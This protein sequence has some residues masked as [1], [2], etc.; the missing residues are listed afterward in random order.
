[1]AAQKIVKDMS[2]ADNNWYIQYSQWK[3]ERDAY[4][5]RVNAR[6]EGLAEGKAQGLAEGKAQGLAEGRSEGRSQG[7]SEK[8]L[9]D[10]KNFL[11]E[12]DSPEKIA[13]CIG[14]PLET[15]LELQKQI[16]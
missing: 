16:K 12:G 6:E 5:N 4:T 13:R 3:A 1:M 15:V 9:E 8:A 7:R 14:L 2:K 11:M 10:A